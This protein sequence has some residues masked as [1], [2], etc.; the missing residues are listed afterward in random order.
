MEGPSRPSP[1]LISFDIDGT[2]EIGEPPGIVRI[3]LV[4]TAK[5]LGYLIGTCSDRTIRDQ[6]EIWQRLGIAADFTVLKHRLADVRARFLAEAYY[7][8]GDTDTDRYYATDA[9]FHFLSA[10]AAAHR[11]WS[12]VLF[13]GWEPA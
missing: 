2:L 10:D 5:R 11:A 8:I 3:A 7:H 4:R 1:V 9:G 12:A 6:E 13:P